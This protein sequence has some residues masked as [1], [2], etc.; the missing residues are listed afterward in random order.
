MAFGEFY[1]PKTNP[2]RLLPSPGSYKTIDY[3]D[4]LPRIDLMT[5]REVYQI[6]EYAPEM[7]V[8]W[9]AG[10]KLRL[11]VHANS[12]S[13]PALVV[14]LLNVETGNLSN[15]SFSNITPAGWVGYNVYLIETTLST[16]GYYQIRVT[17]ELE[18]PN[19]SDDV[20]DYTLI[21]DVIKVTS[22]NDDD[23]ELVEIKYKHSFNNY[24]VVWD[25][26]YYVYF[27][28]MIDNGTSQTENSISKE[29][30]GVNLL[31][32]KS[33][34]GLLV[35]LADIHRTQVRQ[36]EKICQCDDIYVNGISVSAEN[37]IEVTKIE[38]SDLKDVNINMTFKNND[39]YMD[40]F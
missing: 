37:G 23:K 18:D 27:T 15:L 4:V 36:I 35:Q 10:K 2:V 39:N 29:D 7:Y 34:G 33:Y 13:D 14:R 21:S 16:A 3:T 32:S 25:D 28:G 20:T 26:Y 8:D 6:G 17:L 1:I 9:L 24:G 19:D 30:D 5:Q 22:T 31:S 11:Q 40:Y 38:K 12:S